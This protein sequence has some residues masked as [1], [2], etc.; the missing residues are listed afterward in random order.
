MNATCERLVG[1][2]RREVLAG[3]WSSGGADTRHPHGVSGALQ[4]RPAAPG[5]RSASL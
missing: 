4:H 2:P 5:H 3:R 1:T